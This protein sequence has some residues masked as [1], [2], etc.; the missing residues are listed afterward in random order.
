ME[1]TG[2]DKE[3]IKTKAE[4]ARL[5]GMSPRQLRRKEAANADLPGYTLILGKKKRTPDDIQ[6]Y[7]DE[8]YVPGGR[9]TS[10]P[11]SSAAPPEAPPPAA[12]AGAGADSCLQPGKSA[13]GPALVHGG[14]RGQRAGADA[15]AVDTSAQPAR[16]KKSMP[17]PAAS[18][19]AA[20]PAEQ[21][22][23]RVPR[24]APAADAGEPPRKPLRGRRGASKA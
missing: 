17:D 21:G 20:R 15:A 16:A 3:F 5:L 23:A 10:N 24:A 19:P 14:K 11:A 22:G 8:R 1:P 4:E 7:K 12:A 18:A 13:A 2:K 9:G 6:R